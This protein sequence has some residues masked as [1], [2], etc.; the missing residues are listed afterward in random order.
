MQTATVLK[1]NL[2]KKQMIIIG[3]VIGGVALIALLYFGYIF[4][5]G[6]GST[7]ASEDA[8]Q[9]V[10]VVE[11]QADKVQVK[12]ST[13]V[14]AVT[15]IQ[16]GTEPDP[17]SFK[18]L[19]TSGSPNTQ[20]SI[21][22]SSLEPG[23]TYYFQIRVGDETFDN[24]GSFWTF[25]TPKTDA[26]ANSDATSEAKLSTTPSISGV[27]PTPTKTA[28]DSA[29]TV[30]PVPTVSNPICDSNSCSEI[31]E[32]LGTACSTQDYIK[33]IL[34]NGSSSST[35]TI[36]PTATSTATSSAT[37][38]PTSSTSS[39]SVSTGIKNTCKINTLQANS[40]T[41]WTWDSMSDKAKTCSDTFTKYFVQCKSSSFTS[42]DPATWYCNETQSTNTLTIPCS[43]APTPGAGQGVFCRVR[44]ET[45]EGG[46]ANATEWI[47]GNGTCTGYTS[48]NKS[49]CAIKYL[50][51]ANCRN[52]TWDFVNSTDVECK[53]AFS[54]YF[55][56]CASNSNFAHVTTS[57]TPVLWY[58]NKTSTDHYLDFPCFNAPT[59]AFGVDITC[60]VRAEDSY[61]GD[62]HS[63]DWTTTTVLNCPSLTP[64]PTETPTPTPTNTPTPTRTPTPTPTP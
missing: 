38:A 58:C 46:A 20:H 39:T 47:Y 52:W 53:K 13:P 9:N 3:A 40:C 51:S 49:A 1:K 48:T 33:C 32:N 45:S 61:G 11:A 25:T 18:T 12:W 21:D 60:R 27:L 42:S 36:D 63:T 19:P 28:T 37:T 22:I 5:T 35:T 34:N 14:E 56:Q 64:T 4:L 10:Q 23:V 55:L 41:S 24:E 59:P 57:P 62:S 31:Q 16:Y 54:K 50:Q 44:A 17:A 2:S 7:Q 29:T 30:T 26:G 15:A 6:A 8:P 43:G